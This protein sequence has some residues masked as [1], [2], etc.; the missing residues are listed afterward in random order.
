VED[1]LLELG[2]V[3]GLT[4]EAACAKESQGYEPEWMLR[5]IG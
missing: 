4:R 3:G 5:H 2:I 1:H